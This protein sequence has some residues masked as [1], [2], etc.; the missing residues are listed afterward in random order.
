MKLCLK[1]T[2]KEQKPNAINKLKDLDMSKQHQVTLKNKLQQLQKITADIKDQWIFF[3]EAV[4]ES[5]RTIIGRR[6]GSHKEQ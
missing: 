5:A 3:I 4:N 6:R 1:K 2:G